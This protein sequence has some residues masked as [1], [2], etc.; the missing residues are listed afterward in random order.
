MGDE[1][2]GGDVQMDVGEIFEHGGGVLGQVWR[3][4]GL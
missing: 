3:G 4:E 2:L 1:V